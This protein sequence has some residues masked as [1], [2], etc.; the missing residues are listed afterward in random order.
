MNVIISNR[1]QTMLQE[2]NIDVIKSLNGEFD[3]EE[4]I[5]TFQNFYFQRMILDVTAIKIHPANLTGWTTYSNIYLTIF[6]I[7]LI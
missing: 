3:V 1:Y 5:S 6:E 2:L 4:I 7:L